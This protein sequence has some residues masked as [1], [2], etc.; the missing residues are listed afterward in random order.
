MQKL[1]IVDIQHADAM[2]NDSLV[3]I[4]A[5]SED[6]RTP[7]QS[8]VEQLQTTLELDQLL[9]LFAAHIN[10]LNAVSALRF[11]ND[12]NLYLLLG[13]HKQAIASNHQHT[14]LLYADDRYLG[15][16]V[17]HLKRPLSAALRKT[18][19]QC[20]RQ[21]TFPL[22]NAVVHA[23]IKQQALNDYLTGLGNRNLFEQ[24]AQ[25][26]L[27]QQRRSPSPTGLML[28]D[29]DGFIEVN[30]NFGHQRG[31]LVLKQVG[32]LLATAL[33]D[34]DRCFRFGG[35]EFV[36]LLEETSLVGVQYAFAR[37]QQALRKHTSTLEFDL[38]FSAGAIMLSADRDL[39]DTLEQV[40]QA[41]YQAKH[42]GKNQLV[43]RFQ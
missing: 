17:Y 21:L 32:Q 2:S 20:H 24:V 18:L 7:R 30:D 19:D 43:C 14:A 6:F 27:H 12:D 3:S 15:Q 25:H 36:I 41:M 28:L 34:C 39:N 22:R 35:D 16:L 4:I 37:L 1:S 9:S 11:V 5:T 40:D 42:Q 10:Q 29:L 26:A 33:R 31:D 13:E 23:E 38:S 8:L